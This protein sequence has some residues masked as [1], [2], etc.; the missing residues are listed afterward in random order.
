M[1]ITRKN[2]K[3]C[4][5]ALPAYKESYFKELA[6]DIKRK[7]SI[8]IMSLVVIVFFLVFHY[9]PMYGAIIA[10]KNYNPIRGVFGSDW[11]G[12]NHFKN[13]FSDIYF[14]RLI[15]NTLRISITDLLVNFPLAI[16]LALLLNEVKSAAFKKGVQTLSYIPHFISL[17]VVCGMIKQFTSDTGIVSQFLSLFGVEPVSMLSKPEYYVPIHVISS[18]WQQLGWN[19]IIYLAALSGIDAQLYEAAVIDGSNRLQRV[20]H[21]TLPGIASTIVILFIMKVGHLLTVGYEKV[22]LLYNPNIYE[23]ADIISSYVYRK[24]LQE[25]NWS[26]S[27]AVGLFNSVANVILLLTANKV[28][29]KLGQQGLF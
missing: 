7:P 22:I 3:Q 13:F 20:W 8:Y 25:F 14:W 17:V 1:N 19:S 21:V 4:K 29:K 6:K 11:V 5:E 27:T 28:T 26:Y 24:G 16:I 15:R 12:F 2:K 18:T 23:T 9:F 10:F